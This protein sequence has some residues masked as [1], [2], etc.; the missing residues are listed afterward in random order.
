VYESIELFRALESLGRYSKYILATNKAIPKTT[1]VVNNLHCLSEF[2][3]LESTIIRRFD[4]MLDKNFLSELHF[5]KGP[6]MESIDSV[7]FEELSSRYRNPESVLKDIYSLIET[8]WG[9]LDRISMMHV[10]TTGDRKRRD[11]QYKTIT[12]Q[13]IENE[14]LFKYRSST[15][16]HSTDGNQ[17]HYNVRPGQIN[18]DPDEKL[19]SNLITIYNKQTDLQ[20]YIL[21][22]FQS[23][24][25][26]SKLYNSVAF[27]RFLKK[28]SYSDDKNTLLSF[29]YIL[30]DL[31]LSS[32]TYDPSSYARITSY[33]TKYLKKSYVSYEEQH[34]SNNLQIK[35]MLG[36]L[37]IESDEWC[38]L[39]WN[40]IT[41]GIGYGIT[42]DRIEEIYDNISYLRNN[43]KAAIS[44]HIKYLQK[45]D[46]HVEVKK[47]V[48]RYLISS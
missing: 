44:K 22:R 1:M 6:E 36:T 29:L 25:K 37:K 30:H 20:D 10:E 28:L 42:K 41:N 11:T 46:N 9:G 16:N 43:C 33:Y 4:W 5:L 13:R 12:K 45:E 24:S 19:I 32:K 26:A 34:R 7:I 47:E 15:S 2:P 31:I 38:V 14:I 27:M 48:L 23:L 18:A 21:K 35:N 40:R 17:A 39:N 8:I 3:D